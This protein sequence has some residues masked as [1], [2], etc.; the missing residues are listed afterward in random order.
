M[1]GFEGQRGLLGET[2][3]P[4]G[5]RNSALQGAHTESHGSRAQGRSSRLK[6]QL[7]QTHL[8]ISESFLGRQ[9]ATGAYPGTQTLVSVD[10]GAGK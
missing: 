6:G 5:N 7:D 9:E 4:V 8:L 3:R 10:T 1:N 2:R